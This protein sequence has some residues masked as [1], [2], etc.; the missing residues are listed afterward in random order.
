MTRLPRREASVT[1]A[2]MTAGAQ[3]LYS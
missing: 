2:R 1:T 3:S